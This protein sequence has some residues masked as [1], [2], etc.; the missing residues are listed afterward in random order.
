M[1]NTRIFNGKKY[2]LWN[3]RGPVSKYIATSGAKDLKK[4]SITSGVQT[5]IIKVKGGYN[6]YY[7][8]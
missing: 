8:K 4:Y 2:E 5:R 3:K 7:H 6:L 1:A